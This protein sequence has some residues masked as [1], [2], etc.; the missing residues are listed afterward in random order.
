MPSRHLQ[1]MSSSFK[2]CLQD[3]QIFAGKG[4][5][6]LRKWDFNDETV[7]RLIYNDDSK[8]IKDNE[9]RKVLGNN[10]NI[11]RDELEFEFSDLAK[12]AL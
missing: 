7:K 4:G 2:T 10:W 6:I 12:L 1:N 11:S 9:I 3:Q 8:F 5:F